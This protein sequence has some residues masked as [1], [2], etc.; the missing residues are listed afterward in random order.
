MQLRCPTCRASWRQAVLCGRCGSDLSALMQV[1]MRAWELRQ[2]ARTLLREGNQ[3]AEAVRLAREA[4]QLHE[5]PQ[6]RQLLALTLLANQQLREAQEV[7]LPLIASQGTLR[8][9]E[10]R[11]T[12]G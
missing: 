6:A 12:D 5:T 8:G 7:M 1:A 3:L 2:A 10:S 4:C 11:E 9:D